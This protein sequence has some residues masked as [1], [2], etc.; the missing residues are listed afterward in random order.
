LGGAIEIPIPTEDEHERHE[1]ELDY[2]RKRGEGD[3]KLDDDN[4]QNALSDNSR[5]NPFATVT[6]AMVSS[7]DETRKSDS[8]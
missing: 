4:H 8:G 5:Q 6:R 7:S 2:Q 3:D 1:H